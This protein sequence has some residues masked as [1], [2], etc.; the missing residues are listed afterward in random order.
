MPMAIMPDMTIDVLMLA[1]PLTRTYP[2][3]L[4]ATINSAPTRDCHAS[5][6]LTRSPAT[7]DGTDPGRSTSVMIRQWLAPSVCAASIR[8]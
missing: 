2:M 1:W 7:I 4:D 5:P 3:P 8:R 6:A